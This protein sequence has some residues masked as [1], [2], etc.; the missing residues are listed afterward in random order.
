[1]TQD[2]SVSASFTINS[3][4]LSV[5]AGN[6]GSV[7][8]S[9]SFTHGSSAS[10]SA[11]PD[12]GYSFAGWTGDGVTDSTQLSTSVDMTQ[13]RSVSASFT[14]NSYDLSVLAGNGGSVSG[15]GSFTHGSSASISATP[16][17]GYSFAG[18]TGDGVTDSTQLSTSV[19]MT[20]DR[21]VSAS[22]T[23][24]SY[25]LSVV[26]GNGGS[27]SGQRFFYTRFFRFHLR[28]SR[29]RLFFCWLDWRWCH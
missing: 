10:I 13:D 28:N 4:D 16:D 8:G 1:M 2:R 29:H 19:D 15:S 3:Y 26:A 23:I 6:G 12:T 25:D 11:T 22:F 24:N 7:S 18:W 17:T 21:S 27:V 20:Q 5:V 14:I 9:G